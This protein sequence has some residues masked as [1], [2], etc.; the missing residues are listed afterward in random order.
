MKFINLHKPAPMTESFCSKCGRFIVQRTRKP[1]PTCGSM[2]RV[3][4]REALD[5]M[6]LAD[7]T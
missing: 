7:K 3:I 6:G 1:C 2:N 5:K 4:N